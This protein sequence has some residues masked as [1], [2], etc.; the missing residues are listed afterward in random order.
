MFAQ[1]VVVTVNA[2]DGPPWTLSELSFAIMTTTAAYQDEA[3]LTRTRTFRH[4]RAFFWSTRKKTKWS[5]CIQRIVS[6]EAGYHKSTRSLAKYI[7][8]RRE[9][10]R[11]GL[12]IGAH[13]LQKPDLSTAPYT[14]LYR[15]NLCRNNKKAQP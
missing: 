4:D 14:Q 5:S 2:R 12:T 8:H 6:G 13:N 10:S 9:A 15:Y 1:S 11:L 7:I 3:V